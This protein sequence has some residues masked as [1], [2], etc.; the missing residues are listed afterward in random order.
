MQN[1]TTDNRKWYVLTTKPKAEKQ[2]S[3]RLTEN[4]VENF[5]PLQ[6]Q[7]RTWHDRKKWIETPLFNSYI[8]VKTE[9]KLRSKVFEV[10]GLIKYVSI[11][12]QICILTEQEVERVRRLCSY[13]E[14][15]TV[16]HEN[17]ERG[18]EVEI[19]EG[20]FVGFCGQLLEN[21]DKHKLKISIAGL[22]CFATVFI[23]KNIVRKIL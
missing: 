13:S 10:G 2:V 19:L 6:R 21:G 5:L 4:R 23:D 9:D 14:P 7:L 11:G 20:H 16:G 17:F 18:E 15:V 1:V 8:F 3:K 12:G 22:G